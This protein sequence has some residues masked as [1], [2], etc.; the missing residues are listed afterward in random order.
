MIS[1]IADRLLDCVKG[2]NK[3]VEF[4]VSKFVSIFEMLSSGNGKSSAT[5]RS[6]RLKS[7]STSTVN[8]ETFTNVEIAEQLAIY[9]Q[10][11]VKGT[12]RRAVAIYNGFNFNE[13]PK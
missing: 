4:S 1:S 5:G 12:R 7:K 8:W 6:T 9:T 3:K 10:D 11:L 13:N 2:E